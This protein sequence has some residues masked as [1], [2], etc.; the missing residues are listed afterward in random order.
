LFSEALF[1]SFNF[2][3]TN[4]SPLIVAPSFRSVNDLY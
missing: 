3:K 2:Y 4:S 1:N